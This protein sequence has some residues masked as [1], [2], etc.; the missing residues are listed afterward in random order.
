[1][2]DVTERLVDYLI[3]D[4]KRL[5]GG[6]PKDADRWEATAL[7]WQR[8]CETAQETVRAQVDE[9]DAL[10]QKVQELTAAL[11]ESRD[12]NKQTN[13]TPA[14]K[15]RDDIARLVGQAVEFFEDDPDRAWQSLT[16]AHLALKGNTQ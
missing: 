11:N 4:H 3:A 10:N 16:R 12:E 13:P 9:I 2:N 8:E 6:D 14:F 15:G 5:T 1:M 7:S